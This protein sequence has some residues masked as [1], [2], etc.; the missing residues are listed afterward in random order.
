MHFFFLDLLD[1]SLRKYLRS[2]KSF[3]KVNVI[4]LKICNIQTLF[5]YKVCI[6]NE[7]KNVSLEQFKAFKEVLESNVEKTKNIRIER[8]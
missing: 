8:H 3:V 1:M 6:G 4:P 5:L 7:E 2:T